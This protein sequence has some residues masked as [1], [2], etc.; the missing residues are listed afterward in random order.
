MPSR[1]IFDEKGI[2]NNN[3]WYDFLQSVKKTEYKIDT[4]NL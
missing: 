4:D 3:Y 1:R 2:H